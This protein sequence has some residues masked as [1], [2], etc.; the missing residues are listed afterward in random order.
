[1]SSFWRMGSRSRE[2]Q[3]AASADLPKGDGGATAR[4]LVEM[5]KRIRLGPSGSPGLV[6][7]NLPSVRMCVY[8]AAGRA[9]ATALPQDTFAKLRS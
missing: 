6:H 3:R 4:E 9:K 8:A 1:M 2:R 5:R 7:K